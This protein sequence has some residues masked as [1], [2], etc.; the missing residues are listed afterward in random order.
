M[1]DTTSYFSIFTLCFQPSTQECNLMLPPLL[2]VWNSRYCREYLLYY[3]ENDAS[4]RSSIDTWS[5]RRLIYLLT[6]CAAFSPSFVSPVFSSYCTR[7]KYACEW[8]CLCS[9]HITP[10]GCCTH[11]PLLYHF[12]IYR[13]TDLC[14]NSR[15]AASNKKT[16]PPHN[17]KNR[18]FYTIKNP[19]NCIFTP[20]IL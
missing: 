11:V 12:I 6:N 15:Y 16:A 7:E 8:S 5:W 2:S 18:Q 4:Y 9:K 1:G 3:L 10:S 13:N 14:I 17:G 19:R 20:L